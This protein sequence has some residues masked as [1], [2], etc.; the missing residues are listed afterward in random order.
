MVDC[1]L[2][3]RTFTRTIGLVSMFLAFLKTKKIK[4]DFFLEQ[5]VSHIIGSKCD[6]KTRWNKLPQYV[7]KNK[8]RTI[9]SNY[10]HT[11]I[12]Y[13]TLDVEWF[14]HNLA[15]LLVVKTI[16]KHGIHKL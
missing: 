12:R 16:K 15:F 14:K 3:T 2:P 5:N 4:H 11:N 9:I 10:S 1:I 8:E 13:I 6:F 7:K